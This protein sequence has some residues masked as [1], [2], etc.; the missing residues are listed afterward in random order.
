[1]IFLHRF[2]LADGTG[3]WTDA[4]L[5]FDEAVTQLSETLRHWES[6]P[7]GEITVLTNQGIWKARCSE[8]VRIELEVR[9][10]DSAPN[11]TQGGA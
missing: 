3:V 2:Y 11:P 10:P 7:D 6:D 8:V 4:G 1:V 5:P 9:R